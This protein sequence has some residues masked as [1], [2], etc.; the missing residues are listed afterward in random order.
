LPNIELKDGKIIAN[1]LN[2]KKPFEISVHHLPLCVTFYFYN[3]SST[4]L[5]DP[6]VFLIIIKQ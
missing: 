5:I 2:A 6:N 4:I 1:P 3:K